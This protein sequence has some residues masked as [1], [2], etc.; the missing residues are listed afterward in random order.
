[1]QKDFSF[2]DALIIVVDDD[3]LI[4]ESLQLRLERSGYHLAV[5]GDGESALR[6]VEDARPDL[7]ILDLKMPG[8]DGYE[9]CRRLKGSEDLRYIPILML[10]AYGS[11]DHIVKGLDLGAD[12]YVS[13]PFEFEELMVRIKS[14]LRMRHIEKE[15][16]DK[17]THLARVQ[18]MGQLLVT[19]AHHINNSLAVISG[20]AQATK[21]DNVAMVDK[22][23]K[24]CLKESLK[25]EAVLKSLEEMANEMKISTTS[26][27]GVSSAMIDVE[28]EIMQK[29]EHQD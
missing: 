4:Q 18:T 28:E 10:T 22:M 12:D 5:F 11:L 7:I 27:A 1:M 19:L 16:R 8:M 13:K 24:A 21:S 26:Y 25:I 9:V 15:L 3:P 29:L 14:L 6:G 2:N 20:R 23:K 17:E